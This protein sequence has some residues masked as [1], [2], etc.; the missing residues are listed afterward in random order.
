M[1]GSITAISHWRVFHPSLGLL[2][3]AFG[4]WLDERRGARELD[5]ATRNHAT[6]A[7]DNRDAIERWRETLAQNVRARINRP[8][9]MKRA[10]DAANKTREASAPL[11]AETKTQKLEREIDRLASENEALRKRAER[12][13]SL[14]DLKRD[15]VRD[16]ARAIAANMTFRRLTSLQKEI[17]A[18]WRSAGIRDHLGP[19]RR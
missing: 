7:A 13:G 16:I 1:R 6:W 19:R 12:E 3:K 8:T 15:T 2:Y 18:S 4:Q 11:A 17:A 14:F 5:K 10:F 9:T